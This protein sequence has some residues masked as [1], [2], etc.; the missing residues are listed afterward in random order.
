VSAC[1]PS[2]QTPGVRPTIDKEVTDGTDDGGPGHIVEEEA[3]EGEDSPAHPGDAEDAHVPV[4]KVAE[5]TAADADDAEHHENADDAEDEDAEGE[6]AA[7]DADEAEDDNAEEN[8][9]G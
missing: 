9:A 3:D 6:E 8:T 7:A 2:Q 1:Q 5:D 4:D